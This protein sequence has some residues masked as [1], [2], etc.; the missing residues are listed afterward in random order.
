MNCIYIMI[1]SDPNHIILKEL[2]AMAKEHEELDQIIDNYESQKESDRFTLKR[3]KK[4]RLLIKD[5]IRNLKFF[6]YPDI[7][8]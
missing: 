1:K 5:K 2:E 4:Q 6:L 3:L 8:A 7:I